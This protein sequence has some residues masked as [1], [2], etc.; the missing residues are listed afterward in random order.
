MTD[1]VDIVADVDAAAVADNVETKIDMNEIAE[2][3]AE[4]ERL[5]AFH[6]KV[7]KEKQDS[8]SKAKAEAEKAAREKAEAEGNYK[9]L[10][11]L[12]E[13]EF[14]ERLKSY[15]DKLTAYEQ[16][17]LNNKINGVAGDVAKALA[18]GHA[19][20]ANDLTEKL[21]R[22][23]K[24]TDEGLVGI[25]A[26]GKIVAEGAKLDN[27]LTELAR[28]D[29]DYLCDGLQSTGTAGLKAVKP[30]NQVNQ[31]NIDP[32]DRLNRARGIN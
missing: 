8:V 15:E 31:D 30:I 10:L 13:K 4:N 14:N 19:G 28:K 24:M 21:A 7:T 27:Y 11:E 18:K 16:Q 26:K 20:R 5:K 25:D 9:E 1:V 2:I 6:E 22:H 29:F 3:K 17:Q 23:V 12:K 32:I